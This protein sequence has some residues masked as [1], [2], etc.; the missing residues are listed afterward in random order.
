M[1]DMDAAKAANRS[2]SGDIV[3]KLKARMIGQAFPLW[4]TEGWDQATGGFI[5]RLT[6]DG[7]P[8]ARRRG[9]Y[10]SR[11]G[12]SIASPRA[13]SSAGIRKAARSR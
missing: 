1:A 11:P 5:D 2:N 3:A 13:P 7:A 12:R 6:A 4:S 10:S 9:G 8:I